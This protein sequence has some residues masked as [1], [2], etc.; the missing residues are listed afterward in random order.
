MEDNMGS[1]TVLFVKVSRRIV[2]HGDT[3]CMRDTAFALTK[4]RPTLC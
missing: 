2:A 1:I 3:D 4:R